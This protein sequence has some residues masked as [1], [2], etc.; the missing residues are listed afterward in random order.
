MSISGRARKI[1]RQGANNV[2]GKYSIPC[3][4]SRQ[5]TEFS[6]GQEYAPSDEL[7]Y[8]T[9]P[10]VL[11]ATQIPPSRLATISSARRPKSRSGKVHPRRL[12]SRDLMPPPAVL[13]FVYSSSMTR[14][15]TSN[16]SAPFRTPLIRS[17]ISPTRISSYIPTSATKRSTGS[18]LSRFPPA[19]RLASAA[20]V[21]PHLA[22]LPATAHLVHTTLASAPA[23]ALPQTPHMARATSTAPHPS[24]TALATC[25]APS[26]PSIA[27]TSRLS[28]ATFCAPRKSSFAPL[29]HSSTIHR[30]LRRGETQDRSTASPFFQGGTI[31]TIPVSA[32]GQRRRAQR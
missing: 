15:S 13:P 4:Q 24:D 6:E 32:D 26:L 3:C 25:R 22:S 16:S 9:N 23:S 27:P 12:L 28:I 11:R 10:S 20:F 18:S 8:A 14:S 17:T 19:S 7:W 5:E 21:A 29:L 30:E 31:A 1:T 2:S